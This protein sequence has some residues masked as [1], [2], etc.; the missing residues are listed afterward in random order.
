MT[1]KILLITIQT[2]PKTNREE[3]EKK[4]KKTKE[5]VQDILPKKN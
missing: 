2:D 1:L 3:T 5:N 4:K